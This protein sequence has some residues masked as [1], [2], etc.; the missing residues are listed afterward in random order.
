MQK[1]KMPGVAECAIGECAYNANLACHAIA[2]TIGDMNHPRCDTFFISPK[3]TG[4]KSTAGVGACKVSTCTHNRDYVCAAPSIR[5]GAEKNQ[6]KCLT[7][8]NS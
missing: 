3:H 7:F 8:E 6:G 5:V 1:N 2:I 4:I